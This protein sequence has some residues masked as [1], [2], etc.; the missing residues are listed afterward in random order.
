MTHLSSS[1]DISIFH[2]KWAKFAISEKTNID[3][4][5]AHNSLDFSWVFKDF[6]DK[7]GYNLHDVTKIGYSIGNAIVPDFDVTNKIFS[8][9]FNYIVDVVMWPKFGSS[10]IS[11]K[12]V[13][14]TSIL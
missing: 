6:F 7:H 3:C 9:D 2:R 14:I 11:V 10:N 8:R 12:E 5:L 4:I 13:I 1:A